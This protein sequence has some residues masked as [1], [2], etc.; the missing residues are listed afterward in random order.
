MPKKKRIIVVILII[1]TFLICFW[2]FNTQIKNTFHTVFSPIEKFFWQT[3]QGISYLMAGFLSA[4]QIKQENESLLNQNIELIKQIAFL[5][6]LEQENYI[7][8]EVIQTGIE[9]Q[10]D[11]LL[12]EIV[13]KT[14]DQDS[15]IINKG[16]RQNVES[17]LAVVSSRGV[18]VGRVS[19]VW[20]DFS[21]I[22]L[23][24]QKDFNFDVVVQADQGEVLSAAQGMGGGQ[25][26]L[27][28]LP[29]DQVIKQGDS[30]ITSAIGAN[31]PAGILVGKVDNIKRS[32]AEP[33]SQGSLEPLF[34]QKEL[35]HIFIIT[36]FTPLQ[37]Q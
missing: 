9:S 35:R 6:T 4:D 25:V 23:I 33:F 30:V 2:F 19:D 26:A 5:K 20:L 16:S 31:F 13:S 22:D 17:G 14:I 8:K 32:D 12:A 15:L 29:K 34:Q 3:G 7:L 10:F 27:T 21:I 36:N 37:Q 24:S 11:L 1:A 28:L 18:L